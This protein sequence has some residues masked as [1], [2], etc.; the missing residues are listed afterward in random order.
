MMTEDD[1]T[2]NKDL[3]AGTIGVTPIITPTTTTT[4]HST[5]YHMNDVTTT[6]ATTNNDTNTDPDNGMNLLCTELQQQQ[7]GPSSSSRTDI[8]TWLIEEGLPPTC[9]EIQQVIH[10]TSQRVLQQKHVDHGINTSTDDTTPNHHHPSTTHHNN[11]HHNSTTNQS[12]MASHTTNTSSSTNT[13]RSIRFSDVD[14]IPEEESPPVKKE[15]DDD[16]TMS[17][18][19]RP[20]QHH[21][22]SLP[23]PLLNICIMIVGTHGDVLPFTGLAQLL[24]QDGHRVR[25]ATHEVHRHVVESKQIEFYPMEGDPKI[26][27]SWMVQTGGSIWGEAKNPQLLPAKTRMVK[28]IIRSSWPAATEAD[29]NDPDARPF[30]ADTII[31]NPPVAG[32]IHVA[33]ALGIPCHI[34]FPQPWYYGTKEFPHPMAGL[35]Y[36]AGRT[37]NQASYEIFEALSWSTFGSDINKWRFRTLKLPHVYTFAS[38]LN[39]IN[40]AK[41][42]FS[43][44]WSPSFVPK[45]ID[46]PEQCE[47]VGTFFVD[48]A[49]QFD[50]TPFAEL[51]AWIHNGQPKPIFIGFG[52][53]VIRDPVELAETIKTAAQM[54][55]VRVIVQSGWTK[56]DVES[57]NHTSSSS[58]HGGSSDLLRNVGVCPHDWLLPMC[59]A[60]VHHGGAGTVAAGLRYGLPTMVCPFFADQFMWGY[61]VERAGVG[62]K[63]ISVN[64]LTPEKLAQALQELASPK[65]QRAATKLAA[66]IAKEDGI[67]G[68]Y[69]HFMDSLPRENMLCDVSLL[70]GEVVI[71]RYELIG[72]RLPTHG[73]K[74]GTEMA[75]LL[76]AD[77]KIS[78]KSI[79]LCLPICYAQSP[80]SDRSLYTA[81]IRRHAMTTYNLSGHITKV[82]Q[83]V[84]AAFTGLCVGIFNAFWQLFAKADSYARSQGA[85]GCLFGLCIMAPIYFLVGIWIAAL[86]FFDRLAVA[87]ANGLFGE[88]FDYLIDPSWKAKVHDTQLIASEKDSIMASGIPKARRTELHG[89][90]STVVKTRLVFQKCKPF[91]PKKHFHFMVVSL[92]KLIETLRS[93][94][95]RQNLKLGER[96]LEFVITQLESNSLPPVHSIRRLSTLPVAKSFIEHFD[97]IKLDHD[98]LSDDSTEHATSSVDGSAN[99]KSTEE[100]SGRHSGSMSGMK[101]NPIHLFKRKHADETEISFSI[102]IQ[103]LKMVCR[104]KLLVHSRRRSAVSVNKPYS[105]NPEFSEYLS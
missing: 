26:L 37:Q 58:S 31:A 74:I 23:L 88:N 1:D 48:Q 17:M 73:I 53:M 51:T 24:Q 36:V 75:A 96:E 16:D 21:S 68:A 102:F 3:E 9:D 62:P 22:D 60:V 34:M 18:H 85:I 30:I 59:C 14:I 47:V 45:P 71:A 35:E 2:H 87:F 33:E 90:M 44:M 101:V 49:S 79:V 13:G 65:L 25:I 27:S 80:W 56:L 99:K 100:V 28:N 32:H 104:D 78:W 81:G 64:D 83:G 76:E 15:D 97:S 105:S 55:N 43:A 46:W 72:T 57:G 20:Q 63:A 52:S 8:A 4:N 84:F 41:I 42:P 92:S 7:P 98:V 69:V 50:A 29:P 40:L 86:I 93:D 91:F 77:N 39:L 89:A 19:S 5:N 66:S 94:F 70:L 54:A 11:N 95:A 103:A 10:D 38:G 61:F 6:T 12:S 67:K 82:H